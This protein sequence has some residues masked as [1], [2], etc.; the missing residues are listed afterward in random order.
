MASYQPPLF[1]PFKQLRDP[2]ITPIRNPLKFTLF[3]KLPPELQL[4]IW[5]HAASEP[6]ILELNVAKRCGR[7]SPYGGFVLEEVE[8][9]C[10][11]DQQ[12]PLLTACRDSWRAFLRVPGTVAYWSGL[13]ASAQGRRGVMW[14][15]HMDLVVLGR[16]VTQADLEFI[17]GSHQ[18]LHLAMHYELARGLIGECRTPHHSEGY[19][20]R[21]WRRLGFRNLRTWEMFAEWIAP[22]DSSVHASK[23]TRNFMG[24]LGSTSDSL[25]GWIEMLDRYASEP[26]RRNG[27]HVVWIPP[28][29]GQRS[30][31][32]GLFRWFEWVRRN[33]RFKPHER[34][35]VKQLLGRPIF[36]L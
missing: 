29:R 5:E 17:L 33:Y 15:P 4:M 26:L 21:W 30:A 14:R 28:R 32:T 25:A 2:R 18:I 35:C 31:Y 12:S 19:R 27:P 7:N 23:A 13:G 3:P 16:T 1:D 6:H 9:R 36:G 10:M 11:D 8:T 20:R 24:R 34:A 22:D